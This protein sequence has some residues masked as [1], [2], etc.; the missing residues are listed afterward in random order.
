M[1]R[2]SRN[3]W[4]P[5]PRTEQSAIT[6]LDRKAGPAPTAAAAESGSAAAPLRFLLGP[7]VL[8][9]AT[10]VQFVL[11]AILLVDPVPQDTKALTNWGKIFYHPEREVDIYIL[12]VVA[13]LALCL[14][15]AHIWGRTLRRR[16][17][18]AGNRPWRVALTVR[19]ALA[20]VFTAWFLQLWFGARDVV[21]AAGVPGSGQRVSFLLLGLATLAAAAPF[22]MLRRPTQTKPF[23]DDLPVDNA[24]A[25]L[26]AG[27]PSAARLR[28]SPP[29]LLVPAAIF[30]LVYVPAW[31]QL[32]GRFFLTDAFFHWD[33]YAMGPALALSQGQALGTDSY[34]MYGVGWPTLFGLL[35]PWLPLTYGRILQ[36]SVLYGCIY[37][38]GV[39]LLLRLL[40]R[41]P[42]MAAAGTGIAMLQI[43]LGM[44]SAV[45]WV[46]PSLTVL[47]WAFDVWCFVALVQYRNN[48]RPVWAVVA[49]ACVGLAMLFSLDTGIYLA[50]AVVFYLICGAWGD[51]DGAVQPRHAAA[52]LL[53]ALASLMAGLA[54][55][56]R[57]TI[58][59]RDF[60]VG[61]LEPLQDYRG[62]FAQV[63]LVLAGN[64][65]VATFGILTVIY[66]AVAGSCLAKVLYRRARTLDLFTG[67]FAVYG[68]MSLI[69]FAGRSVEGTFYRLTLPLAF[70]CILVAGHLY[71]QAE[72]VCVERWRGRGRLVAR[73]AASAGL[74]V[75]LMLA[76]FAAP[77]S[78]LL[79]PVRAYP[80][81][82]NRVVQGEE[83]R[84][85]CL[86]EEPQDVC[87][88]PLRLEPTVTGF[89]AIAAR[90]E[91]L[92]LQGRSVAIIDES[93]PILYLASGQP[94]FGRYPRMFLNMYSVEKEKKVLDA[95]TREAPDYV[96][97][98]APVENTDPDY[99]TWAF[100]GVGPRA[101]TPYPDTWADLLERVELDY[102][103]EEQMPPFQL[104][105]RM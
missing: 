27:I 26:P 37:F 29:D 8:V 90:L 57:G 68:L 30:V 52:L 23:P 39:Y 2:N 56:A 98:R 20:A 75:L 105:A 80:N 40:L 7:L 16:D 58:L 43:F 69:H 96:L 11:S 10:G 67:T 82:A 87:G 63:P 94:P 88:L 12:G 46:L 18:G 76:L 81:L 104:W 15:L 72:V 25:A 9:A 33:Y 34:A 62:G 31:Q 101:D 84:G 4:L 35:T 78:L 45:V 100:F 21:A 95:L 32:A 102:V 71:S 60:W 5:T 66:L 48:R 28:L 1:S 55:A 51:R 92:N 36:L 44:Q 93:G 59:S 65:T 13:S 6:H 97:T 53:S 79:D 103:L 77:S 24:A 64:G 50:A 38:T 86:L 91:M 3:P 61:W 74:V 42:W 49:G 83:P 41:R 19:L 73:M 70:I 85:L 47:R 22:E 99:E 14:I 54:V 89:Q 17:S